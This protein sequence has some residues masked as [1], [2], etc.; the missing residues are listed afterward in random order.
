MN[1]HTRI[2][3]CIL[4]ILLLL[5]NAIGHAQEVPGQPWCPVT[6]DEAASKKFSVVYE[7][8]EIYF[9][10]RGCRKDFLADP[11]QYLGNLG[12]AV[13]IGDSGQTATA[14]ATSEPALPVPD[15]HDGRQPNS[16]LQFIGKLHPLVVHFP[17]AFIPLVLFMELY[18]TCKRREP[19]ASTRVI[20]PLAALSALAAASLGWV[21][22][23]HANYPEDLQTTLFRHRW[24]G[25]TTAVIAVA[26]AV[27]QHLSQ[28]G[29]KRR[30]I[31]YGILLGLACVLVAVTGHLGATLIY[32]ADYFAF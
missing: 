19:F 16:F 10:C 5:L 21:D 32:G 29:G 13:A 27:M 15:D 12:G 2:R 6:R 31:T 8:Q 11:E 14:A 18:T 24:A 7:A 17:I 4:C 20:L 9:C 28:F 26:A 30:D 1:V 25:V 22:A 23:M 3:G